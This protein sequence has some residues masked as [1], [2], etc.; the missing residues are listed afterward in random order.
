MLRISPLPAWGEGDPLREHRHGGEDG[1]PVPGQG[2]RRPLLPPLHEVL[3]PGLPPGE[4]AGQSQQLHPLHRHLPGPGDLSRGGPHQ[5]HGDSAQRAGLPLPV[6]GAL[7]RPGRQPAEA[8]KP[9]PA[10][11]GIRIHVLFRP[12]YPCLFSGIFAAF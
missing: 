7:Q 3:Q 5:P 4:R 12:G 11:A 2:R 10:G 1:S 8:G 9:P 6:P